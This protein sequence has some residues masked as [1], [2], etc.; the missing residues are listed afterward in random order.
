MPF[1][2]VAVQKIISFL[3]YAP[4]L[5][6]LVFK[7]QDDFSY[8]IASEYDYPHIVSLPNLLTADVTAPGAGADILRAINAPKLTIVRLDGFRAHHFEGRWE[9]SLTESLSMTVRR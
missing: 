2:S 4:S 9:E 6:H 1:Y 8:S 5:R 7:G 3:D